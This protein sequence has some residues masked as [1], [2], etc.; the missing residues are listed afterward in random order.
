M[1][2]FYTIIGQQ[3][4]GKVNYGHKNMTLKCMFPITAHISTVIKE[5]EKF[6]VV[7]VDSFDTMDSHKNVELL[8]EE[9]QE[10]FNNS[11]EFHYVNAHFE[12]E[13]KSQ[14]QTF[15]CLYE[16][17]KEND[18]VYFDITFGLK[19]TP[20]TVFVSCN[21]AQKFISGLK[22]C[23]VVYAHYTFGMDENYVHP[24]VDVTSLFLL[25][26]LIESISRFEEKDPMKF[27]KTVFN[28]DEM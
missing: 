11:F 18:Q 14:I 27:L 23:D 22:I 2:K 12:H 28:F 4:I 20:M 24:I 26:N 9:L 17:F 21:Y 16:T 8:K 25:N 6:E 10:S 13:Q 1:K 7:A 15:M 3:H 19:P 5:G